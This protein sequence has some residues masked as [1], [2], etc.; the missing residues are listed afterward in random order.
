MCVT[1]CGE[2][3]LNKTS[4]LVRQLDYDKYRLPPYIMCL[5][6]T[7]CRLLLLHAALLVEYVRKRGK[8]ELRFHGAPL[9]IRN[10]QIFQRIW[11]NSCTEIT[12]L[13][14]IQSN[15]QIYCAAVDTSVKYENIK[16]F[17]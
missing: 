10:L 8:I 2:Q 6:S 12:A 17:Q 1:V 9:E 3:W 16:S 7:E 15:L 14:L 4:I 11:C 5:K 13:V